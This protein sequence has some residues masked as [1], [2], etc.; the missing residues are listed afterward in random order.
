MGRVSSF[1][2]HGGIASAASCGRE[3][4]ELGVSPTI[5]V[6]EELNEPSEVAPT[7]VQASVTDAP[8][9]STNQATTYDSLATTLRLAASVLPNAA[10]LIV[11]AYL[12]RRIVR[13]FP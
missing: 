11:P 9:R 7:A 12:P 10:L 3:R 13:A 2:M 5:S 6:N 4:Y 8:A 1:A